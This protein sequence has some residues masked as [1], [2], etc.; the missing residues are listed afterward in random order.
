MTRRALLAV[1]LTL[2]FATFAEA[3]DLAKRFYIVPIT[4]HQVLGKVPAYVVDVAIEGGQAFYAMNYGRE[5]T[6]LAA[7]EVTA[8][9]HT[10][11]TANLDVIAIP[12]NLDANISA[13]ALGTVQTALE[14]LKIPAG[15]VTTSHTYRQ[16]IGIVGRI[17]TL[18][19][20]FD[21]LNMATFFSSGI[22]LDTRVNQLTVNQRNNLAGAASSLGLETDF[23]TGPMTMRTVL[24]TWA[25]AMPSFSLYGETF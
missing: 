21:G 2:V 23:V 10:T 14:N 8:A 20:R 24:K 19:Q 9:Q 25:D 12:A 15:W 7:I 22:T 4:T 1:V 13:G 11:I 16:V 17:F 6:M 3:Q 18:M 5:Q